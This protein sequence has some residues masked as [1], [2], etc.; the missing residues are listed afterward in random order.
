MQL[1]VHDGLLGRRSRAV[2]RDS[3]RQET[4]FTIMILRIIVTVIIAA[5]L[6]TQTLLA[7]EGVL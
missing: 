6:A 1:D 4:G 3:P 7:Q 2:L 5:G